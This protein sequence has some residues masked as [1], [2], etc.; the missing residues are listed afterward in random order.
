MKICHV[1]NDLSRGGAE[2]HLYSLVKLQHEAGHQVSVMLLGGDLKNFFSLEEDFREMNIGLIRFKGPK[3]LQG[4]NPLSIIVATKYFSKNKFDIVHSHS[5]RSDFLTYVSHLFLSKASKWV[6]TVHGKYGTYLDGSKVIDIFRK[7]GI[8]ILSRLWSKAD[9][10]IVISESIKE[11]MILLNKNLS[12]EVIPYGINVQKKIKYGSSDE[13]RIGFLGRLNPNKGIEDL[14][15]VFMSIKN[16]N[17]PTSTNS[18]LLIGGVGSD[19][20]ERKLKHLANNED[21]DFLGYVSDREEFF[22]SINLFVFTSYSE[23]LGL[24]LLEAMSYGL[25]CIARDIDPMNKIIINKENGFLFSDNKDLENIIHSI[26]V[27][28]NIEKESVMN[29]ALKTIENFYSI[30]HMY[31]RIEKL[32]ST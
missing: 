19:S 32:Y 14:I 10:I 30:I 11:W 27:K 8:R 12:P 26:Q 25:I 16:K 21:V 18:K 24:A 20:Y 29:S 3:K 2:S 23:G 17:N 5:P 1:I 15:N 9:S 31:S 28:D 4:F 6:V 7:L 13:P 22:N